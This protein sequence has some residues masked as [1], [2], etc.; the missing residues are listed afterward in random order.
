M[1][2]ITLITIAWQNTGHTSVWQGKHNTTMKAPRFLILPFAMMA[3]VS[4]TTITPET[5]T[6]G[7]FKQGVPGGEVVQT[8]RIDA[9]VT[10][11]DTARR[12]VTL[13]TPDSGNLTVT[14]G[15][16]VVN[17][18]QIRVGDQLKITLTEETIVRMAKP[19]EKTED[20]AEYSVTAARK[21]AKPGVTSSET[22]QVI[23]TVKAIDLKKH[24]ATLLL[25]NGSTKTIAVRPDVDLTKRRIGEKVVIRI[26]EVFAIRIEKP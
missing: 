7:K 3:M 6:Q 19:G 5:S 11:I 20:L 10:A 16:D 26:T 12:R 4:C 23:A 8:S 25:S 21:G 24:K 13:V 1:K 15:P 2:A 18:D 14:A 9:T 17:F 22:L